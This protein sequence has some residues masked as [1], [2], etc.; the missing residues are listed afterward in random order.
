MDGGH[1]WD[2]KMGRGKRRPKLRNGILKPSYNGKKRVQAAPD[3]RQ[4]QCFG[5]DDCR[6]IPRISGITL[7]QVAYGA[8]PG[9]DAIS[10]RPLRKL[11]G[12]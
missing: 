5:R 7:F 11:V 8:L 12:R 3:P 4:E 1:T 9:G 10:D 2:T 6:Q